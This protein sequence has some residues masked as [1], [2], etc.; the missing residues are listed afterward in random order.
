MKLTRKY[1]ALKIQGDAVHSVDDELTL[2]H[3]L[4]I[5]INEKVFTLTMQT[6]GQEIN[7]ARGLLFSEGVFKRRSGNFD[8]LRTV[9][10]DDGFIS[11]I[12][13]EVD[14]N[15]L[16]QSQLNKRSLLSV[17]SCGI[18]GKTELSLPEGVIES[19]EINLS[20][21]QIQEMFQVM[22]ERQSAFISSGGCHA[23]AAFSASFEILSLMEDIGRHNA[24]DKVI[25]HLLMNDQLKTAKFLLVS[26]RLSYEIVVKCFAAGIPFLF[27]VSAPSS[28]AVDFAKELGI[29]LIGFCRED[30]ATLYSHP[31]RVL[32]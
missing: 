15:E 29:T 1:S 11:E 27:A 12:H 32:G 19:A 23:S 2:E 25:G 17:A 6:P 16:D 22:S 30:R 21:L 10:G 9:S 14:P 18:C 4:S 31:E 3:P 26:G 8:K 28:L 5:S 13:L 20:Q 24:V 7:L